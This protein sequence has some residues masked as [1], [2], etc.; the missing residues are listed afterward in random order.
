MD[1]DGRPDYL[2]RKACNLITDILE[3]C[4]SPLFNECHTEESVK[5]FLD[6]T[7]EILHKSAEEKSNTW[8]PEKCPVVRDF[9]ERNRPKIQENHLNKNESKRETLSVFFGDNFFLHDYQLNVIR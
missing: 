7:V 4:G 8:N 1:E 9:I 6:Y 2:E 3:E 5:A